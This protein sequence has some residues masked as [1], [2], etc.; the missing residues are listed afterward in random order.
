MITAPSMTLASI[1]G[2]SQRESSWERQRKF[3]IF[4][5]VTLVTNFVIVML[6]SLDFHGQRMCQGHH[7]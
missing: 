7:P 2:T 1:S 3:L 6:E 5:L 4:S